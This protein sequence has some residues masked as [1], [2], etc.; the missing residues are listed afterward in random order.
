M[1]QDQIKINSRVV[2]AR[3]VIPNADSLIG[4]TGTVA[5]T[6][7]RTAG[8]ELDGDPLED[9]IMFFRRELDLI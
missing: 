5:W 7:A 1:Q 9:P 2:V 8:V 6:T 3:S 4:K